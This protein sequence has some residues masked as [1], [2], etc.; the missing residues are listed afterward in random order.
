MLRDSWVKTSLFKPTTELAAG[1]SPS[2]MYHQPSPWAQSPSPSTTSATT[3]YTMPETS[4]PLSAYA[5]AHHHTHQHQRHHQ[6]QHNQQ[7]VHGLPLSLAFPPASTLTLP[8]PMPQQQHHQQQHPSRPTSPAAGQYPPPHGY[9]ALSQQ[10][11]HQSGA[12]TIFRRPLVLDS[13]SRRRG[14]GDP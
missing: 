5:P 12:S 9:D 13:D 6:Q 14:L 11:Q 10:Q 1:P 4:S 7:P 3:T 8:M 2:A